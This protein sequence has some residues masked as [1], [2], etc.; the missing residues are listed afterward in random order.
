MTAVPNI[1]VVIP[2]FNHALTVGHVIAG[3][4]KYFPVLVVNDGS[5][6][7][8]N[9]ILAAQ[10]GITVVALPAN[11]GK[12]AAL[13][14]GFAAAAE[15][16]FTHAITLDADG[17]HATT[18]LTVLPLNGSQIL[19]LR[20]GVSHDHWLIN[21]GNGDSVHYTL[22]DYLRGQGVNSLPR[23]VLAD[24][25]ARDCGGAKG[26]DEL[27]PV[28][29]LWTSAANFRSPAYRQAVAAFEAVSAGADHPDTR[30]CALAT[31]RACGK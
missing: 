24:G 23:L 26:V 30:F 10:A 31:L 14:A 18:E 8:T 9:K 3:A 27:F 7:D 29:E 19:S 16:G 15:Q 5:T 1:C 11:R 20:D 12:G 21:C 28:G 6:D 22:K 25:T 13:R 4:K 17:Q 2:V